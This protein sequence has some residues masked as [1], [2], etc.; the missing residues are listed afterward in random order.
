MKNWIRWRLAHPGGLAWAVVLFVTAGFIF[1]FGNDPLVACSD[2]GLQSPLVFVVP[3][4]LF[5]L[6]LLIY[7]E[8]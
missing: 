4:A 5:G 1:A 8:E 6:L 7:C 2:C 3:V